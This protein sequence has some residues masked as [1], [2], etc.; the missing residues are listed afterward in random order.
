MHS[1]VEKGGGIG[2]GD[3]VVFKSGISRT[4]RR[5]IEILI[6]LIDRQTAIEHGEAAFEKAHGDLLV[7]TDLP[8]LLYDGMEGIPIHFD[9]GVL[10]AFAKIASLPPSEA[11]EKGIQAKNAANKHRIASSSRLAA[12]GIFFSENFI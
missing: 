8:I 1:Y 10:S 5:N 4:F 9:V 11:F 2:I 12:M 7:H 3:Y 6:P